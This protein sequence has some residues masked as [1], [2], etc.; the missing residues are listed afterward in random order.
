MNYSVLERRCITTLF[1]EAIV[2][3]PRDLV[4]KIIRSWHTP[5]LSNEPLNYAGACLFLRLLFSCHLLLSEID[6]WEIFLRSWFSKDS[7]E[8][9]VDLFYA[10]VYFLLTL[11][12]S[13]YVSQTYRKPQERLISFFFKT[14]WSESER[15]LQSVSN[16]LPANKNLTPRSVTEAIQPVPSRLGRALDYLDMDWL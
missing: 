15:K 9:F 11:W 13:E 8:W 7:I 4:I 5:L 2:C 12:E 14:R 6:S 16:S 1:G 3:T 10:N